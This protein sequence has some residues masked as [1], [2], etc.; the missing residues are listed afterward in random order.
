M[1]SFQEFLTK[2]CLDQNSSRNRSSKFW[3]SGSIFGPFLGTGFGEWL[4]SFQKSMFWF[5]HIEMELEAHIWCVSSTHQYCSHIKYELLTPSA[6]G[7]TRT[8]ISEKCKVIF[9]N[10][11]QKMT[12]ILSRNAKISIADFSKSF[13]SINFW[14]KVSERY[15]YKLSRAAKL[16]P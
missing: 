7:R 8:R 5:D 3:R 16:C 13:R 4:C 9:Q 10:L 15:A 11:Y 6:S 12:R 14:S 1:Q 2:N